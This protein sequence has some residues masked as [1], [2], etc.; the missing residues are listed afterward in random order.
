MATG[1]P[2]PVR[3]YLYGLLAPVVAVLVAYGIV[4]G[5]SAPLWIALA[6]AVLGVPAVEVARSN[7]R[8]LGAAGVRRVDRGQT[9]VTD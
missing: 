3:K 9:P 2:E 7:V 4:D 5:E 6:T 1:V 8:P